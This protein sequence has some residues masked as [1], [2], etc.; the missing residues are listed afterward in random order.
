MYFLIHILDIIT[1]YLTITDH[2]HTFLDYIRTLKIHMKNVV[3]SQ[4]HYIN[5]QKSNQFLTNV[6]RSKDTYLNF[7]VICFMNTNDEDMS[8]QF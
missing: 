2:F 4:T 6:K 1:T 5:S 3:I 7:K 8:V